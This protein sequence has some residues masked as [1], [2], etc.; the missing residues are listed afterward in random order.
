MPL[1][2]YRNEETGEET[3]MM[4][5]IA[6]RDTVPGHRRIFEPCTPMPPPGS[7]PRLTL[8]AQQVLDGYRK[9]EERGE[10]RFSK[11]RADTVKRVWRD[12]TEEAQAKADRAEAETASA[13]A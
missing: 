6:E 1:Y 2:R 5:P 9:A 13:T 11:F 3:Y 10:L 7:G 4:R 8:Q 12:A